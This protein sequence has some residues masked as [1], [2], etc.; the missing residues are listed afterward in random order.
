M[1]RTALRYS[2]ASFG[3]IGVP[4][5]NGCQVHKALLLWEIV[6]EII[7][8]TFPMRYAHLKNVTVTIYGTRNFSGFRF[9]FSNFNNLC[10]M[11][12]LELNFSDCHFK[13]LCAVKRTKHRYSCYH[14]NL[15]CVLCLQAPFMVRSLVTVI[16]GLCIFGALNIQGLLTVITKFFRL[17]QMCLFFERNS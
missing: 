2:E 7:V 3:V 9:S 4:T 8:L 12:H 1:K 16:T 6:L 5:I 15:L 13:N 14:I 10:D 17:F 11:E